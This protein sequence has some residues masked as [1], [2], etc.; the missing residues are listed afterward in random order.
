[1]QETPDLEFALATLF[2]QPNQLAKIG[3]TREAGRALERA[4]HVA[5]R[6]PSLTDRSDDRRAS[7]PDSEERP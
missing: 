6:N 1:M 2:E 5:R 3:A 4:A 7:I